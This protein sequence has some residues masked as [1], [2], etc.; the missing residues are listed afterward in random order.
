MI[1]GL[2]SEAGW[3]CALV[4]GS[5]VVILIQCM[6]ERS[7]TFATITVSVRRRGVPG[8]PARHEAVRMRACM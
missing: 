3:W 6:N 2:G 5:L 7:T 1:N 8:A 4:S